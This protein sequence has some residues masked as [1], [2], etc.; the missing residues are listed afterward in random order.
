M[1]ELIKQ[2]QLEIPMRVS[3]MR[4]NLIVGCERSLLIMLGTASAVMIYL[5]LQWP[6]ALIVGLLLW[7]VGVPVLRYMGRA[8]PL[9]SEVYLRSLKYQSHYS[10]VSSPFLKNQPIIKG[11]YFKQGDFS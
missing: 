1:T 4:P 2:K 8:D 11:S 3:I 10:A 5:A 9:L 6:Y 7:L